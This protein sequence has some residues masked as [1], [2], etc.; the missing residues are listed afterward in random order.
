M[1]FWSTGVRKIHCGHRRATRRRVWAF[2]HNGSGGDYRPSKFEHVAGAV[3]WPASQAG[4][5]VSGQNIVIDGGTLI[6]D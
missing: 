3:V 5:F 1:I 6:S 4:S 2:G